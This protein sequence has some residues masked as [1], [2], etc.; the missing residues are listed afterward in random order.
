V[1]DEG[2]LFAE[3]RVLGQEGVE[4]GEAAQHVLRQIGTIDADDQ[5]LPPPL[6]HLALGFGDLVRSRGPLQPLGVD[7]QRVGPGERPPAGVAHFAG[8]VVDLDVLDQLVTAAQ[9]VDAV[10]GGVEA[11]DVV[12]QHPLVDRVA[13]PRRQDPPAV[14]L[15]PGD[16]DEVV[17][18]GVG[19]L[20]ADHP[21]GG[22]EVVI[23]QHHQGVLPAVDLGEDR[24]G[25]VLVDGLVAVVPG[26]DLLP[27][28]VRRVGDVPE[29]VLDEPEDRVGDHVVEA[30]V[31]VGVA[32]HQPHPVVDPVQ[33]LFDRFARLVRHR[34]VLVGHR[35]GDPER[36]AVGDES[37]QRGDQAAA[38]ATDGALAALVAL[39]LERAAVGD[40][41]QRRRAHAAETKGYRLWGTAVTSVVE[42]A[43]ERQPVAQQARGEEQAPGVLLALAAELL[44]EARVAEDL[45]AAGR[46]LRR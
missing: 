3:L 36:F 19:T 2:D 26:V 44:A 6:E 39:E 5:V 11:D 24:L 41:D 17:E 27:A 9:E 31:G 34:D 8:V 38:A 28:D 4:C 43:E 42:I 10:G 22:V 25:D 29:V 12:R 16:V 15:R 32:A 1:G 14:R 33:L 21:G 23:V 37:G 35:R 18:E 20:C 45:Q 46:A 30:V 40:D 7:P 13:D